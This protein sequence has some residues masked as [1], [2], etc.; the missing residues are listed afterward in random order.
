MIEYLN[1]LFHK[2]AIGHF[3][4]KCEKCQIEVWHN[5]LITNKFSY[6]LTGEI[7]YSRI[8]DL[9]CEEVIIKNII[10]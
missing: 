10:E 5:S 9:S 3:M 8:L 1:H 2:R 4:F 7:Q 6:R